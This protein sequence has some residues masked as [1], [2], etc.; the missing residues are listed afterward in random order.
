[1]LQITNGHVC[2]TSRDVAAQNLAWIGFVLPI[3]FA[4]LIDLRDSFRTLAS[5]R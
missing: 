3:G 5:L 1:V 4:L 2:P